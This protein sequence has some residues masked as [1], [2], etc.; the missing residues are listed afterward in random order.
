MDDMTLFMQRSNIVNFVGRLEREVQP[1]RRVLLL[2]LLLEEENRYGNH[3]EQLD[4]AMAHIAN[5]ERR[6]ARQSH[7]LFGQC[8]TRWRVI[9]QQRLC[10]LR[11]HGTRRKRRK[12]ENAFR[13]V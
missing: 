7:D 11:S 4:N 12:K 10:H 3:A 9:C 1:D 8:A 2:T 13:F 6:I 5:G